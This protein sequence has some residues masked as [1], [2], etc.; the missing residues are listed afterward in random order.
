MKMT[1]STVLLT[2]G[3]GLGATALPASSGM[4]NIKNVVVLVQ[5]NRSF[6]TLAGG[7]TYNSAIDGLVNNDYCNLAN[8]SVP[9]SENICAADIANNIA[10]DD[11]DHS[12]TG[13]NMQVFGTY[14]PAADAKSSMGGFVTEQS[15]YYNLQQ[16]MMEA[17]EVINYY[18]P[19]LVPVTEAMAENYVLFDRWFAAVPGPTNPNRA[20]LTSGTVHGNVYN[21]R[22]FLIQY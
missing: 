11:P 6:D 10:S 18:K 12:I 9:T 21:L 1:F 22:M 4:K 16:N 8:V 7:F 20:Y 15:Y 5:E 3:L 2:I 14:H 17:A 19:D 13:G